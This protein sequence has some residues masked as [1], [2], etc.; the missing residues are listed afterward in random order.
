MSGQPP[1]PAPVR[2]LTA[3]VL[4]DWL[5]LVRRTEE[6]TRTLV[7]S[8]NVFPVPDS[9]TG[10]NVLLTVRAACDAIRLLPASA[11]LVQVSRAAADGA[12]RG[13]RGNSGL[14]VSQ[15]L[16]ALADVCAEGPDPT[17]LRPV[18][19]VH[20][21]ERIADTTWAAVKNWLSV[22]TMRRVRWRVA[23]ASSTKPKGRPE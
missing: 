14:L 20:A 13:A 3:P 21:Y 15:A 2:A 7:D 11:D 17:A 6:I 16:A 23:S 1:T 22:S 19:I 10:T 8:L 5:R 4:R 18:E 9:D 12:I